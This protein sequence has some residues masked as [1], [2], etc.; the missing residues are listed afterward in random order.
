MP[1]E[2]FEGRWCARPTSCNSRLRATPKAK[3]RASR[4]T[5]PRL[6]ALARSR[7]DENFGAHDFAQPARPASIWRWWSSS[8]VSAVRVINRHPRT[9]NIDG[10]HRKQCPGAYSISLTC[11]N[12][13][14]ERVFTGLQLDRDLAKTTGALT[15]DVCT[16]GKKSAATG[17]GARRRRFRRN[18]PTLARERSKVPEGSAS[19]LRLRARIATFIR[20]LGRPRL[21]RRA[22]PRLDPAAPPRQSPR[23]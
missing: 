10:A 7:S 9:P 3:F 16:F 21:S 20:K 11:L 23:P 5:P 22:Q 18:S 6:L 19:G 1:P 15:A 12:G 13:E 2:G 17:G 14:A 8:R 4:V